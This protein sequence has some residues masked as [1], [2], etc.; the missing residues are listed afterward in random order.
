MYILIQKI[1]IEGSKYFARYKYNEKVK[2]LRII[3]P[4]MSKY[5]KRFDKNKYVF[6]D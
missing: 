6:F 2:L 5:A 3:C 1:L 4:S